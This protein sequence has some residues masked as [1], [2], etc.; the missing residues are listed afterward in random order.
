MPPTT[1]GLNIQRGAEKC[2]SLLYSFLRHGR[3]SRAPTV[4]KASSSEIV[5]RRTLWPASSGQGNLWDY[6][7]LP[8][9][10]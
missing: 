8:T 1:E 10:C 4:H 9:T 3:S 7:L 2:D 6:F 5:A